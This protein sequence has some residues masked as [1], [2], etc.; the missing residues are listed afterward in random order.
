MNITAVMLNDKAYNAATQEPELEVA[1]HMLRPVF[2][3]EKMLA[4]SAMQDES[5]GWIQIW[6]KF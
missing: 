5:P 2:P 4:W 6:G 1:I 3:M